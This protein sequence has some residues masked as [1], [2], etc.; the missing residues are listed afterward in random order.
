VSGGATQSVDKL[1]D[2]QTVPEEEKRCMAGKK[3]EPLDK[4]ADFLH[5]VEK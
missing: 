4:T 1:G 3:W 5:F 2:G